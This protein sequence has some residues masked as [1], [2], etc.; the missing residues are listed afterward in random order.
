M[1]NPL[2]GPQ[3]PES[4]SVT[5][6]SKHQTVRSVTLFVPLALPHTLFVTLVHSRCPVVIGRDI[7]AAQSEA[8]LK[9]SID[10]FTSLLSPL[11][12]Y[13]LRFL[14]CAREQPL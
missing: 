7:R 4:G 1:V 6:V 3:P 12:G 11:P 2:S 8:K 14:P 10:Q 5:L 9:G 13:H